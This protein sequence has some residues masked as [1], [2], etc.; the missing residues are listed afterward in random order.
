VCVIYN[1]TTFERVRNWQLESGSSIVPDEHNRPGL[2][3]GKFHGA[4]NL[5]YLPLSI[6]ESTF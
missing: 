2:S 6:R 1:N 3:G 4:A 5:M